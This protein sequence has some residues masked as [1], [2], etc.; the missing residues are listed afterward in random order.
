ME[1]FKRVAISSLI[2]VL[3]ASIFQPLWVYAQDTPSASSEDNSKETLRTTQLFLP[4]IGNANAAPTWTPAPT[5]T[6]APTVTPAPTPT[7][8]SGGPLQL[9][10]PVSGR[11]FAQPSLEVGAPEVGARLVLE[12]DQAQRL[13]ISPHVVTVQPGEVR[14]FGV[15]VEDE[16]GNRYAGDPRYL[17]V[18]T[19]GPSGYRWSWEGP[20]RLRVEAPNEFVKEGFVVNVR[21]K[22]L[23]P[24]RIFLNTLATLSMVKP[25][26]YTAVIAEELVGYPVNYELNDATVMQ[27]LQLFAAQ[28]W[29]RAIDIKLEGVAERPVFPVLVKDEAVAGLTVGQPIFGEGEAGFYGLLKEVVARRNGYALLAVELAA[30]WEV[31]ERY[32]EE[33]DLGAIWRADIIPYDLGR[34]VATV[35]A[36][37]S[38][39][40]A[41]SVTAQ[42]SSSACKWDT[43]KLKGKATWGDT[44]TFTLG[45]PWKCKYSLDTLLLEISLNLNFN[46]GAG[47]FQ[48][49]SRDGIKGQIESGVEPELKTTISFQST[50]VRA[51]EFLPRITWPIFAT[52]VFSIYF[53]AA[54][55]PLN[56]N[57]IVD[58]DKNASNLNDCVGVKAE[59]L[60]GSFKTLLASR[61]KIGSKDWFEFLPP[62]LSASLATP[63]FSLAID[64]DSL[65]QTTKLS[66]NLIS[67]G[68]GVAFADF[69]PL[70]RIIKLLN[71]AQLALDD[72][73]TAIF[74]V[75]AKVNP[76][77][78]KYEQVQISKG[79]AL[80]ET[81]DLPSRKLS[82]NVATSVEAKGFLAEILSKT[83]KLD[84]LQLIKEFPPYYSIEH[85]DA[86]SLRYLRSRLD[87]Q[88]GKL[89]IE[90]MFQPTGRFQYSFELIEVHRASDL[91]PKL[92]GG[93]RPG[94][95][96]GTS[97]VQNDAF[98]AAVT[99]PTNCQAL[100]PDAPE[101]KAIIIGKVKS[102]ERS[103]YWNW[104]YL[105]TTDLCYQIS[106]QLT[107]VIGAP[108]GQTAEARGLLLQEG[109]GRREY[110]LSVDNGFLIAPTRVSLDGI[111][112]AEFKVGY[113]CP[114][115]GTFRATVVAKHED[116]EVA[117]SQVWVICG[118][119]LTI[120]TWGDP[121]MI[122]IDGVGYDFHAQGEFWGVAHETL[123]LQLRFL[124]PSWF[125]T[126][127]GVAT[128]LGNATV[129]IR[130]DCRQPL[131]IRVNATDIASELST[132]G[133]FEVG[134]GLIVWEEGVIKI[135]Y[136][137]NNPTPAVF[138]R[139][140]C[141][142]DIPMFGVGV[143][144]PD[145]MRGSLRGLYGNANRNRDDDFIMR[146]GQQLATPLSLQSLYYEFGK[147][148]EVRPGERLFTDPAPEFIYPV[149]P[150]AFH[151]ETQAQAETQC[152]NIGNAVVRENCV[153]DVA[154]T[155]APEFFVPIAEQ[156]AQA[157]E[158]RGIEITAGD[159]KAR[160]T[161]H[162]ESVTLTD[163]QSAIITLTNPT[164]QS[165]AYFLRLIGDEPG[166]LVNGVLL[167]D[168]EITT[169]AQIEGGGLQS[170]T[171]ERVC[172]ADL[173]QDR[174]FYYL[175]QVVENGA[176]NS[177]VFLVDVFCAKPD[178]EILT[179]QWSN[180]L[181]VNP[182]SQVQNTLV[183]SPTHGFSGVVQLQLETAS[184]ETPVGF[185]L[186]PG[187]IMVNGSNLVSQ[188]LTI[189]VAND[190]A[191]GD[192][193]LRV[194][195]SGNGVSPR[196]I[197]FTVRVTES[198]NDDPQ[199]AAWRKVYETVPWSKIT[200]GAVHNGRFYIVGMIPY[201]GADTL[202]SSADGERWTAQLLPVNLHGD[203]NFQN[204]PDIACGPLG[205]LIASATIDENGVGRNMVFRSIDGETW[206]SQETGV[207]FGAVEYAGGYYFGLAENRI[208]T[209]VDGVTWMEFDLTN[210]YP[211]YLMHSP[212]DVI[213]ESGRYIVVGRVLSENPYRCTPAIWTSPDA[214]NW[215]LITP[216]PNTGWYNCEPGLNAIAYGNGLYVAVGSGVIYTSNDAQTWTRQNPSVN[217]WWEDVIFADGKFVAV[218]VSQIASS[219]EGVNWMNVA[220]SSPAAV[221]GR[222]PYVQGVMYNG[223]KFVAFSSE[224]RYIWQSLD[225]TTW[226]YL[227]PLGEAPVDVVRG[228]DKFLASTRGGAALHSTDGELWTAVPAPFSGKLAYADNSYFL[229]GGAGRFARSQDGETWTMLSTGG[230]HTASYHS[231]HDLVYA[232]DK[233]IYVAVGDDGILVSSD[234]INWLSAWSQDYTHFYAVAYGNGV[235]VAGGNSKILYSFN[236]YHWYAYPVP[237]D[238][239]GIS[240][241]IH[242][243]NRFILVE[244]WQNRVWIVDDEDLTNYSLFT[245]SVNMTGAQI[246]QTSAGG[247]LGIVPVETCYEGCDGYNRIVRSSDGIDWQEVP[248]V[249]SQASSVAIAEA[250]GIWVA[251]AGN[252]IFIRR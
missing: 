23:E 64:T 246:I 152:Q 97:A 6:P 35:E 69:G 209:S 56:A 184:G 7:P 137:G 166:L 174:W 195:V 60:S 12:L 34:L 185:T 2:I 77:A 70:N 51:P 187:E 40:A 96:I 75:L 218:G 161:I 9:P 165:I 171:L 16:Q 210:A 5:T 201:G 14:W 145:H 146:N 250:N 231:L 126:A 89:L 213:Y 31:F 179:G 162:P 170:V 93:L 228:A 104:V 149:E 105:G 81:S 44:V 115:E 163:A 83:L 138:V 29:Q 18:K 245:P 82:F 243:Q 4:V 207:K 66:S 133:Y 114:A 27:R 30:P 26:A 153:F 110:T 233:D 135:L 21:R 95:P 132:N 147:S 217:D 41:Q 196:F 45:V 128:K 203:N 38:E 91:Q 42:S 125:S 241:I 39:V 189:S 28:E 239:V 111:A 72:D 20:G 67:A 131:V 188:V 22:D 121:H 103:S 11:D 52:A 220:I 226:S 57:A 234:G 46:A 177:K 225:G 151:P 48:V 157:W 192:Y 148:W 13:V 33:I 191:P 238:G 50:D 124:R 63:F 102:P 108:V 25:Q 80:Q 24:E 150:P 86:P 240:S 62:K 73:A 221:Y 88:S 202:W 214:T 144:L 237:G 193:A 100:A 19:F 43:P 84:T 94:R 112:L 32:Q 178:V 169:P 107:K 235:F 127:S 224:F 181:L 212:S 168:E 223:E 252:Q 109:I 117:R 8:D 232:P 106:M 190:V 59:L 156:V 244:K 136:P 53:D 230:T 183:V 17:E 37:P 141:W 1:I 101:R 76:I 36:A 208:F 49:T 204:Q 78:A 180:L 15:W 175:I 142:S 92:E 206:T 249:E 216:D 155:G 140:A 71:L 160:L 229:L 118:D 159:Q 99:P 247:L 55:D 61:F 205:C 87:P 116:K 248:F 251:V 219:I 242:A 119:H 143:L 3:L 10:R 54:L 68:I 194:R 90:G 200:D 215:T 58:C 129:E 123:P 173:Q 79:Y 74:G 186:Q 98:S 158:S 113:Q 122:T 176:T 130:A 120:S 85:K 182:G 199:P 139:P 198:A 236:G 65:K 227:M 164:Q 47:K 134:E 154:S 211:G 222:P 197:S 167:H 172:P